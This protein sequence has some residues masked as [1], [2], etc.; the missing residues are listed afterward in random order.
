MVKLI[1]KVGVLMLLKPLVVIFSLLVAVDSFAM[2]YPYSDVGVKLVK[3]IDDLLVAYEICSDRSDCRRKEFVFRGGGPPEKVV[4][5]VFKT[6][7]LNEG[8]IEEI[9]KTCMR[10]F[11]SNGMEITVEVKF[12]VEER[13]DV[14]RLISRAKPVIYFSMERRR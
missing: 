10:S 5:R 1:N 3:E 13:A 6:H 7:K 14:V 12:Y 9:I 11:Y 2:K 4:I 8:M